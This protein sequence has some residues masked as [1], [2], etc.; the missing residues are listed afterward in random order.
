MYI[1]RDSK[2][3]YHCVYYVKLLLFVCFFLV[4]LHVF[5]SFFFFLAQ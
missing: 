5:M 1:C 2:V 3:D 4:W